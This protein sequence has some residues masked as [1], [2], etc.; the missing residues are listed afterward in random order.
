M[1]TKKKGQNEMNLNAE[2]TC[3]KKQKTGYTFSHT[4]LLSLASKT[5]TSTVALAV[6]MPSLAV[7]LRR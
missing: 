5:L 6:K 2:I 7:M 3:K 1:N 4:G